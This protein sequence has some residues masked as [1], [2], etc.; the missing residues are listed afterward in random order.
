[1]KI[2]LEVKLDDNRVEQY[3]RVLS[4]Y[5]NW[6]L[7]NREIQLSNLLN[8]DTSVFELDDLIILGSIREPS[9]TFLISDACFLVEK[10][11]FYINN[12]LIEKLLVE[13]NLLE[14]TYMG[15]VLNNM[16]SLLEKL[17]VVQKITDEN[18]NFYIKLPK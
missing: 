15:G 11:I 2:Y 12:C 10:M 13:I 18:I 9:E 6:I 5:D 16:G 1:M 8:E 14:E 7:L 3:N 4:H 17:E